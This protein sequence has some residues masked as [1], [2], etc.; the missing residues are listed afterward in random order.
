MFKRLLILLPLL[1]AA[2]RADTL[3]L[4]VDDAVRLALTNNRQ[5]ALAQA[6]LD[7][8]TA[9]KGVA[10]GSFLPQV[11][12][13]GTYTRLARASELTTMA[14]HDSFMSLP[15]FDEFG[16]QIGVTQPSMFWT[17]RIDTV[18]IKLGSVNNY[19]LG[20]SAQQTLFTWGKLVNA[21][22]I[23]G[24]S[25]DIQT[26]AA[27]QARAQVRVDA[28]SGFY[29]ALLA[30]KTANLMRESYDQ[31]GRHVDQVQS[32]YDNG[33]ATRLDVMK[34][35]LGL[36]NLGAQL[37]QVENG[38]TLALAALGVVVG[39]PGDQPLALSDNLRP[40]SLLANVDAATDSALADRPELRQLRDA[41]GIATLGTKIARAANLPNA[42]AQFNYSYANPVGFS[43]AWG[44]NWN[45]TAGISMP[46]FTGLSNLNKLRQSQARQRQAKVALA[47]VEDGIRIEVQANVLALNQ[48]AKN[49]GYQSRAVEVAEQALSLAEQRYQ[50]G[51]LTNLEYMDTQ[52]AL[53][54]SRISYVNS[55]AN[56]QVAKARLRKAMGGE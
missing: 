20:V 39:L 13:T 31:L 7:E 38:A 32:L 42:F 17:G 53:T 6:R 56:Y 48:E 3:R 52:L 49:I 36:T 8:A 30:R 34:A 22:R 16:N 10:F 54:Q 21:Y 24:L 15:V 37:S 9:G 51:L 5:I 27:V 25:A 2:G 35:T 47:Q 40:E 18:S 26:A 11:N 43:A 14:L 50:N 1:L 12:G 4:T 28:T 33:M 19:S 45:A 44:S 23:A 46:L 41:L 29:Q 55:L